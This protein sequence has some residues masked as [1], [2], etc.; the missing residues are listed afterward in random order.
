MTLRISLVLAFLIVSN[1]HAQ[2][3]QAAGTVPD[4]VTAI[5]DDNATGV[6]LAGTPRGIYITA[7]TGKTWTKVTAPTNP[8][9]TILRAMSDGRILCGTSSGLFTGL[10]RGPWTATNITSP[11]TAISR[12]G[13]V[14][15]RDGKIFRPNTSFSQWAVAATASSAIVA[16]EE[17]S[18]RDI[19][20][21]VSSSGE[22]WNSM[23][24]G[25]TWA[26]VPP[27]VSL[28]V[29]GLAL[30]STFGSGGPTT[31]SALVATPNTGVT[32]W[33]SL[34]PHNLGHRFERT[35]S[36]PFRIRAGRGARDFIGNIFL[37]RVPVPRLARHSALVFD[38]IGPSV[39]TQIR[40]TRSRWRDGRAD[41]QSC[42]HAM[43]ARSIPACDEHKE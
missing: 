24:T 8:S 20:D 41:R 38:F 14:G 40:G 15:T 12:D 23:D 4:S 2:T 10:D 13:F 35:T 11:V 16:A 18:T 36:R 25:L 19:L 1:A 28:P 3:W 6:I 9:I 5:C 33:P 22:I 7:D 37:F 32:F 17:N 42:L 27:S 30:I 29:T 21:A 43:G 34:T 26:K 31:T 39:A